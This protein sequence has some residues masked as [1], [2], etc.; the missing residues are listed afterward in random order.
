[1]V[2]LVACGAI[3]TGMLAA[4]RVVGTDFGPA[5]VLLRN[6]AGLIGLTGLGAALAGAANAWQLP[7]AWAAIQCF[8]AAPGGPEWRQAALWMVQEPDNRVAAATSATF[9]LAGVVGYAMR[10]G[11]P[12]S[13]AEASME[14]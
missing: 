14:Q 6:A 8:L 1:V 10:V 7:L 5:E 9:L 12:V 3:V 2:H 11:P 13:A 4:A